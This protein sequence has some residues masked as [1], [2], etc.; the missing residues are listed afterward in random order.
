MLFINGA[1]F[2]VLWDTLFFWKISCKTPGSVAPGQASGTNKSTSAFKLILCA[3]SY[4][5]TANT[6]RSFLLKPSKCWWGM[7]PDILQVPVPQTSMLL[8]LA[9]ACPCSPHSRNSMV[10]SYSLPPHGT[11]DRF[12]SL[13]LQ[14]LG[15]SKPHD[16]AAIE[17][18]E[19]KLSFS[20]I[21]LRCHTCVCVTCYRRYPFY[22]SNSNHHLSKNTAANN[23]FHCIHLLL[24]KGVQ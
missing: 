2:V 13:F 12:S 3:L 19:I 15:T 23:I 21:F 24:E 7:L 22:Y 4:E 5:P 16:Q 11:E 18:V 1:A 20:F 14:Q 9:A 10:F 8:W 6:G 17:T